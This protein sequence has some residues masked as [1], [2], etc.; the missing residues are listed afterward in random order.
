LT[1]DGGSNPNCE[2]NL[3]DFYLGLKRSI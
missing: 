3:R 2:H 1:Q